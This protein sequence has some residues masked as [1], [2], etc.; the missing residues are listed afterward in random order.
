MAAL[1][2]GATLTASPAQ[3]RP[4]AQPPSSPPLEAR[5]TEKVEVRLLETSVLATDRH[6]RGIVDLR[7]EEISVLMGRRRLR[8]AYLEPLVG[9]GDPQLA[10]RVA[11]RL[12]R[13]SSVVE[14]GD[15]PKGPCRYFALLVDIESDPRLRREEALQGA[16]SFAG[17]MLAEGNRL[18]VF[19]YDGSLHL[20]VPF[21]S[22][23]GAARH[24]IRR[25]FARSSRPTTDLRRRVETLLGE[26]QGC[27]RGSA[28]LGRGT[29]LDERCVRDAARRYYEILRPESEGYLDALAR[30]VHFA[31]GVQ[32][33]ATIIALTHGAT[34]DPNRE[35]IAAVESV[36]GLT[37][38]T[39]RLKSSLLATSDLLR[40]QRRLVDQALRARVVFD[41]IDRS[42]PP[43]GTAGA[44]WGSPAAG[45]SD[46]FLVAFRASQAS[47]EEVSAATGGFFLEQQTIGKALSTADSIERGRYRLGFYAVPGMT[48][49][50]L[51][52]I[53]VRS[54]RRG[55]RFSLGRAIPRS[56]DDPP[57]DPE[58]G[59]IAI[60][61]SRPRGDGLPGRF[62]PFA[63]LLDPE[64]L[65]SHAGRASPE[66]GLTLHLRLEDDRGRVLAELFRYVPSGPG[67]ELTG[68]GAGGCSLS[69][70]GSS[71]CP[72]PFTSRPGCRRPSAARADRCIA[73]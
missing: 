22:Q 28:T 10:A 17:R 33:G 5:R 32:G 49:R 54:R 51:R 72:A 45:A 38:Q 48:A 47:L 71:W 12:G 62:V 27:S 23:A 37:S 9:P 14:T 40:R 46:P 13:I 18:A 30:L 67:G 55:I 4:P 1:L 31:A 24:A 63:V 60:D 69:T 43:S 52:R 8:T 15:T 53:R 50:D 65:R 2:L 44:R 36:A 35:F 56:P 59:R 6:E 64:L 16:L 73:Y 66:E 21:T 11:L 3:D 20:E 39:T 42:R 29:H 70:A 58:R 25:A 68:E 57:T 41:V 26:L 19:S 34:L 7:A 61:R